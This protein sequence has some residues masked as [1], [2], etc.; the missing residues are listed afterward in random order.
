MLNGQ[1]TGWALEMIKNERLKRKR[2]RSGD[3]DKNG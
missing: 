1:E 3:Q 2:K